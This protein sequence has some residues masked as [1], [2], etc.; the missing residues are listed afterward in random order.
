MDQS[1]EKIDAGP[2]VVALRAR[3]NEDAHELW[4]MMANPRRHHEADGSGTVQASVIGPR[5]LELGDRFRVSMR[6]M[7]VPYAIT[8]TVTAL[9]KDRLIEWQHPGGHR[10]RWEFEPQPDGATIVTESFDY[11]TVRAPRLIERIKAPERNAVGIR[12]SLATLQRRHGG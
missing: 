5:E 10:W 3:V 8:S 6:M 9:E 4:R 12:D 2:R 1:I 7:G 11:S